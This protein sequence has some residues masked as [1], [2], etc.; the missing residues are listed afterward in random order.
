MHLKTT[1]LI[2]LNDMEKLMNKTL[3]SFI[4]M[5]IGDAMG[6]PVEFSMPGDFEP[7]VDYRAGGPFNLPAGYWTDDT[8][9]AICIAE[10]LLLNKEMN[11]ESQMNYFLNWYRYGYA[12][13][14]GYCFDIGNGTERAIQNFEQSGKINLGP[15]SSGGNGSL[16]RIAPIPIAFI[17]HSLEEVKEAC[18]LNSLLTHNIYTA[19]LTA[20]FGG[21]LY[22]ALNGASKEELVCTEHN[23]DFTNVRNSGYAPKALS[24]ALF[25]FHSTKTF[26]EAIIQAVNYGEDSDTIGAITGQLAGAFYG[27]SSISEKWINCLHKVDYLKHLAKSI[28]GVVKTNSSTVH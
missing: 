18:R 25:H 19:N 1:F 21:L 16:M 22:K 15:E 13:S 28:T 4:G 6:A 17:H 10:S 20:E 8:S 3:G 11:L 7:I 24:A 23:L 14:T 26:E 27:L 12:S 5:A 9:M 2:L